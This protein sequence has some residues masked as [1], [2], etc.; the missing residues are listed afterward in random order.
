MN[1]KRSLVKTKSTRRP[2]PIEIDC[3]LVAA[4]RGKICPNRD[5]CEHLVKPWSLPYKISQLSD[6]TRVF[7]VRSGREAAVEGNI[8]RE[9][10][11]VGWCEPL[12][13]PFYYGYVEGLTQPVLITTGSEYEPNYQW[14]RAEVLPDQYHFWAAATMGITYQE[15]LNLNPLYPRYDFLKAPESD[16]PH[17][18]LPPNY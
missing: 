10:Y 15:F 2:C 5:Y 13:I 1:K 9:Q 6:G 3:E 16:Y 4:E 11:L 12:R 17:C 14:E 7:E 18:I 8:E